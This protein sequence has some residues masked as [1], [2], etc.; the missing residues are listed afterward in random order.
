[1]GVYNFNSMRFDYLYPENS[2]TIPFETSYKIPI[3]EKLD[4]P[5]WASIY[6]PEK[7]KHMIA[8]LWPSIV[9]SLILILITVF[10]F[11]FILT[12]IY[13]QKKLSEIKSD[14]INNMTHELKTPITTVSLAIEA[15]KDFNVLESKDQ[16]E[17]YLDIAEGENKRLA[18]LVDRILKVAAYQRE[19]LKLNT[20]SI[21]VHYLISEV[22]KNIDVQVKKK[23]G[24][25]STE[26]SAENGV[27]EVDRVHF[28][29]LIYNLLDNAIKYSDSSPEIK[30]TTIIENGLLFIQI[31]D[32]GIGISRQHQDK[33]FD[34]FYRI[35]TGNLH[36]VKGHG[37]GL[38][39][40]KEIVEMHGGN[41][42]LES[43]PGKGSSFN[44]YL[45][46]QV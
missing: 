31:V 32:N 36:G 44:I 20:E 45:P 11:V 18:L 3:F 30:V 17:K 19:E 14:F 33:I 9:S 28:N 35:P 16:T 13:R 27:F 38:S 42:S 34:K 43:E 40:V 24:Q 25:I 2:D 5:D 41:I 1:V 12:T 26:F 8:Q 7:G 29:N 10:S 39:Y 23:G 46:K 21:D 4:S 15:L 22:I 6:F 37:L